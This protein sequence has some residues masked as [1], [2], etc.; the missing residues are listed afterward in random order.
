MK[1]ELIAG[2]LS[3]PVAKSHFNQLR[4]ECIDI[5]IAGDQ[6]EEKI[7]ADC[8]RADATMRELDAK[9][10]TYALSPTMCGQI[11]GTK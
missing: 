9:A 10:R 1:F 5:L 6:S 2:G 3:T 7:L 4:A 11:W 8:R